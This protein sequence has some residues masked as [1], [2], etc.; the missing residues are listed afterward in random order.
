MN[1]S[2]RRMVTGNFVESV[3]T[4]ELIPMCTNSIYWTLLVV[5]LST[6]SQVRAQSTK[7]QDA[8]PAAFHDVLRG[9][10]AFVPEPP[11]DLQQVSAELGATV[12]GQSPNLSIQ[13]ILSL[14]NNG[15]QELKIR[16]PLDSLS[17]NFSTIGK[18]PVD[19]PERVRG[20]V[21]GRPRDAM[22]GAR[23][24][25]PYPAPIQFRRIVRGTMATYEKEEAMTIPP[26]GKIQI[27]FESEPVVME[28]I[29]KALRAEKEED[30]NSFRVRGFLA[31]ISD[32]PER[33]GRPLHSDPILLTMP[34]P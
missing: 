20:D 16:D 19:V 17:L 6:L 7:A 15:A 14:Q 31:L 8:K 29:V 18:G 3:R 1:T 27:E 26:G 12:L 13:F 9:Q 22:P 21:V 24:D 11:P 5:A 2:N 33:G 23:H 30:A 34:P 4:M 10:V 28:R 32:P 25:Q